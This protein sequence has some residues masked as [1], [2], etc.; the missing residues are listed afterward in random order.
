MNLVTVM[1]KL[2]DSEINCGIK[3]FWDN[4]FDVFLGDEMNGIHE[5]INFD[6][7][8]LNEAGIW[9]HNKACEFYPD[10]EYA[11]TTHVD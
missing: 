5:E 7:D 8:K 3:S 4:G 11:K 9:L 10:S 2:Y 1:Q 6:S